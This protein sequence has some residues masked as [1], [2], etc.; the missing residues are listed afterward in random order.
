MRASVAMGWAA[1]AVLL[2]SCASAP[3]VSP[4]ELEVDLPQGWTALAARDDSLAPAGPDSVTLSLHWWESFGD[5]T[6]NRLVMETLTTNYDLRAAAARVE[7]ALA[8]AGIQKAERLPQL[9]FNG[10]AQR[11]KQ[12]FPGFPFGGSGGKPASAL[13]TVYRTDFQLSW[14]LDLWGRILKASSAALSDAQ[15]ATAEYAG[16]QLSL[17]GRTAKAWFTVVEARHQ[18]EL[19]DKTVASYRRTVDATRSRY[20][21]GLAPALNLRL[22]L[23]DYN[24]ALAMRE[25]RRQQLDLA[26][27]QLEVLLG[28]YPRADVESNPRL[29]KLDSPPPAGLPADLLTRR[30]DLISAERR[31]AAAGLRVSSSKRALLPRISLTGSAGTTGNELQQIFDGDFG[32][33]S[34]LG[35][36]VQPIFQGGRLRA[37]VHQAQAVQAE[38]L[39]NYANTALRAFAEVENALTAERLLRLR[40]EHLRESSRQ[41]RA[42]AEL[43]DERYR[44]GL[45]DLIT[46][47]GAQRRAFEAESAWIQVRRNQL[48][49]RVDLILA[50][51][52]GFSLPAPE[53]DP[54]SR[55]FALEDPSLRE[56][57][58]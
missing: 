33:W 11:S 56:D 27:R 35:N 57:K 22:S 28:R 55:S 8:I 49:A 38:V 50:L 6:L 15:A 5:S 47:L 30:P 7:Q 37:Q 17:S 32:M 54:T 42:A 24:A 3:P 16:A 51:G 21:H 52:G 40:E 58:R 1:L 31:L 41:A 43:A 23:A 53:E 48:D 46:L 14:E 9:N 39:S 45:T 19:A 36:L 34:L 10:S 13:T 12:L 26:Q 29:P 2:S 44:A 18:L 25:S 4:P 20:L